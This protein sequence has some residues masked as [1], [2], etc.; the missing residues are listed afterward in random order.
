MNPG[1]FLV[2]QDVPDHVLQL[3]VRAYR[4]LTDAI[5]VFIRVRISPE[6][7]LQLFVLTVSFSKTIPLYADRERHLFEVAE[8]CAQIIADHPVNHECSIHFAWRSEDLASRQVAPLIRTYQTASLEPFVT[9]F[10][11]G[12][13]I[14]T[15]RGFC[16]DLLSYAHHFQNFAADEIYLQE[17]C[18]H[19]FQHDLPIDVHHVRVPDAA[20]IY[21]LRHLHPR[22]QLVGLN[23][24]GN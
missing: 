2:L 7:L 24:N 21:D 23:L 11:I 5:A 1:K 4:E 18:A 9:R 14:A 6:I 20:A 15:R 3:N 22:A 13:E 10:K 19:S 12:D 17:I 16:F 8:L